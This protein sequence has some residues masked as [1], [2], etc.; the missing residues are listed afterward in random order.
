[1]VGPETQA[2]DCRARSLADLAREADQRAVRLEV[3]RVAVRARRRDREVEWAQTSHILASRPSSI[4]GGRSNG[5][6]NRRDVRPEGVSCLIRIENRLSGNTGPRA[7]CVANYQDSAGKGFHCVGSFMDHE[8]PPCCE[9]ERRGDLF[10]PS[11]R[12]G[13]KTR[14]VGRRAPGAARRS[15]RRPRS[16]ARS[17][18]SGRRGSRRPRR[19]RPI[20]RAR[21][22][23]RGP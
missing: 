22:R 11:V 18:T 17:S 10:L 5:S 9:A 6:A 14:G 16:C 12:R 13:A 20:W 23:G 1:M 4:A 19:P 3:A 7:G 15:T 8:S 2:V 21:A